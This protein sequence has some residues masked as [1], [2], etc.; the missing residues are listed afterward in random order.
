MSET[1]P[2]TIL[3]PLS[4]GK[5]AIVDECDSDLAIY[6]WCFLSKADN[7]DVP[8]QVFRTNGGCRKSLPRHMHRFIMERVLSRVLSGSELVDHKDGNPLNN[9]RSNLR[10]ATRAQNSQNSKR[11]KNNTTGFKGVYFDARYNKW[12]SKIQVN[13]RSKFLGY[14]NTPEEAFSAYKAA[15]LELHGEFARLE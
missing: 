2:N 12:F 13:K 14:H 7:K 10:L 11:Y 9:S 1:I 5:C 3:I 8:L 4:N 6:K 15:A